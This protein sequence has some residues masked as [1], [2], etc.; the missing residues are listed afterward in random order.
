MWDPVTVRTESIESPLCVWGGLYT[1]AAFTHKRHERL[2]IKTT[3][4][5]SRLQTQ[6]SIEGVRQMSCAANTS[7]PE[8]P[9]VRV[10]PGANSGFKISIGGLTR[11]S[12]E[13]E[14]KNKLLLR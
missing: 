3:A 1:P 11:G 13:C 5:Q 2:L 12:C 10:G 9:G 6:H 7:T 14:A 4:P 8:H